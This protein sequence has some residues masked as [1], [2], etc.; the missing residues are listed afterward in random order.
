MPTAGVDPDHFFDAYP[1]FLETSETGRVLD[2]LNARYRMLVHDLRHLYEGARVLDLASHD[3]RFTWA[4]L[5]AGAASVVGIEHKAHLVATA[6]AHLRD[7]GADPERYR[8]L[9]GDLYDCIAQIGPVDVVTCFGILYHLPDHVRLFDAIA[10]LEPRHV[11]V[12]TLISQLPGP[13]LELRSTDGTAPPPPGASLEAYPTREALAAMLSSFGWTWR[14]LDWIGSGMAASSQST[15]YRTG[16]RVSFVVDCPERDVPADVRQQ[17][18]ARVL[19]PEAPRAS[20]GITV[21]MVARRHGISPQALSTWVRH[22]ERRRA[23]EAGFGIGGAG[24]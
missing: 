20:R 24:G 11:V 10:G 4:V 21:A 22:E 2:R 19:R 7:L 15:D 18:V 17:A 13:V 16:N 6:Q 9:A 8:F 23:I 12:D 1:G 14:E 5:D 3:G